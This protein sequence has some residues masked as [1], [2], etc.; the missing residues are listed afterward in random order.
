[1]KYLTSA[2]AIALVGFPF[3]VQATP[4]ASRTENFLE[5]VN[6]LLSDEDWSTNLSDEIKLSDGLLI[7][8]RLREGKTEEE[9]DSTFI[10]AT[11]QMPEVAQTV[12]R[13]YY[14]SVFIAS[15]NHLCPEY[16]RER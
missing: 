11:V 13:S 12:A 10:Q 3:S 9:L 4:L 15:T 7:C 2:L 6:Y 16:K 8:Q 1:M 14:A 5:S